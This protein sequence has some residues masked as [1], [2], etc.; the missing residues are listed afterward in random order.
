MNFAIILELVDKNPF[1]RVILPNTQKEQQEQKLNFYT[2]EQVAQ[3]LKHLE[4][5]TGQQ[6]RI[7]DFIAYRELTFFRLLIFTGLRSSEALAL[8]SYTDI[9][10]AKKKITI[11]KILFRTKE[12]YKVSTPK[13]KSSNRVI[14]LDDRTIHLLKRQQL[15]QKEFL[16]SNRVKDCP[17]VFSDMDGNYTTRQAA[18]FRALDIAD[19]NGLPRIGVHSWRHTHASMLYASG[20][21]M[22]EAQERLSHSS[23]EITMNI[24]THL[25]EKDKAKTI[26]K[27]S[28][29][30][31]F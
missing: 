2:P 12:G 1:D 4:Q 13:T 22:K 21:A 25:S 15:K 17:I 18:Y 26:E 16:F 27:L 23:I 30:A 14:D 24:Y 3:V 20:V 31:N 7:K 8:D 28:E 5:Q 9:D 11:N 29:F 10:F 6:D 19:K